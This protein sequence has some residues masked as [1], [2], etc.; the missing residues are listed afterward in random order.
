M[1]TQGWP[2]LKQMHGGTYLSKSFAVLLP[3]AG[4]P[5]ATELSARSMT[6]VGSCAHTHLPVSLRMYLVHTWGR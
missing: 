4:T 1:G 3:L 6:R 2:G 5:R